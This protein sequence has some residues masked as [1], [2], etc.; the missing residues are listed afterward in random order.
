M[1]I[2]AGL[3]ITT[4]STFG[5]LLVNSS[6]DLLILQIFLGLGLS[7]FLPSWNALYDK[8]SGDGINDG[9]IWGT[10][11]GDW[12]LFSGV[13]LVVGGLVVTYF[14][15]FFLFLFMGLVHLLGFFHAMYFLKNE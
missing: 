6:M 14:S 2:L 3:F 4:L 13:A 1:M 12:Y 11:K 5:Y 7:L 9:Y 8:Y 15:F 10:A